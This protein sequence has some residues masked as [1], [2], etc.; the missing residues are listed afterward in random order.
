MQKFLYL[1]KY[2]NKLENAFKNDDLEILIATMNRDTLDFLGA[3]FTSSPFHTFRLLIVNQ[4]TQEK[5]VSY[6]HLT[7]PTKA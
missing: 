6:T 4:T 3:I 5:P 2:K 1:C 7:L